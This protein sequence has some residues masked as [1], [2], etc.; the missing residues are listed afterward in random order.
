MG[1]YADTGIFWV[2]TL[3]DWCVNL[4]INWASLL[5]IS[6]EEINIYIFVFIMPIIILLSLSTNIYLLFFSRKKISEQ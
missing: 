4:L 2:D 5:G 3:Y 6:Y 1:K